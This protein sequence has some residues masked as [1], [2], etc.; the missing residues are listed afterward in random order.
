MFLF[1]STSAKRPC[2]GL[3]LKTREDI[4]SSSLLSSSLLQAC[5]QARHSMMTF[6][7]ASVCA[8]QPPPTSCCPCKAGL[9][10]LL[11]GVKK[12]FYLKEIGQC[13]VHKC[14]VHVPNC[15]R[16][17]SPRVGPLPLYCLFTKNRSVAVTEQIFVLCVNTRSC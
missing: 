9:L 10:E 1:T 13:L 14:L 5:T 6:I 4:L 15:H 16:A 8:S 3:R 11:L 2:P 7:Q 17:S 12:I